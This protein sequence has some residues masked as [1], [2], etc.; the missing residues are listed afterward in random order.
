MLHFVVVLISL[1]VFMLTPPFRRHHSRFKWFLY[2]SL[3]WVRF[4][5]VQNCACFRYTIAIIVCS[6]CGDFSE[7]SL[8]CVKIHKHFCQF[9]FD[10]FTKGTVY[11]V[12]DFSTQPAQISGAQVLFISNKRKRRER[13]MRC[14]R[15]QSHRSIRPSFR[16]VISNYIFYCFQQDYGMCISIALKQLVRIT[17]QK[18]SAP[19]IIL[20]SSDLSIF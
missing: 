11:L 17:T 14:S 18:R 20:V 2:A 7:R 12:H 1:R 4:L 16:L 15:F 5:F 19:L 8:C 13:I 3:Q 9:C 10:F 6:V